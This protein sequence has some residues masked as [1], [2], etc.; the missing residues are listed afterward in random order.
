MAPAA[1]LLLLPLLA[2]AGCG[3]SATSD[4][5][6]LTTSVLPEWARTGFSDPEPKMP[7]VLGDR[8]E[9]TAIVF[10][11][12][13]YAPPLKDR[14]NKILWVAREAVNEPTTLKIHAV[15][16]DDVADRE[17][18]GGPGPSGIDLPHAGCWHVTLRWAGRE[19]T[20]DL[21]YERP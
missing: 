18:A 21:R 20:L 3:S 5:G 15:D 17:V 1:R 7:H 14:G 11:D 2:L 12:A 4:C 13:L 6:K 19:D 8:G 10:G 9:I 16:G